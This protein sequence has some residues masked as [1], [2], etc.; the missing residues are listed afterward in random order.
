M[1]DSQSGD[2]NGFIAKIL[3]LL[4]IPSIYSNSLWPRFRTSLRAVHARLKRRV[5]HR[6]ILTA[7]PHA[8]ET[9]G[10]GPKTARH[11]LQN[12]TAATT[13]KD[14]TASLTSRLLLGFQRG[15]S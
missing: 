13:R 11:A 10:Y 3:A 5:V 8:F 6:G 15:D 12:M 2:V 7:R 9:I 1:E 14:R 4:C